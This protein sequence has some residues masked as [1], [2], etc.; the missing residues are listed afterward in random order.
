MGQQ[1]EI[2]DLDRAVCG[3]YNDIKIGAG[4]TVR[5]NH[6]VTI[7]LTDPKKRSL[8]NRFY[9]R[10]VHNLFEQSATLLQ[11]DREMGGFLIENM[12]LEINNRQLV[13]FPWLLWNSESF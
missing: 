13:R 2:F 7:K 1:S 8:E 10:D 11:Q 3:T 4:A 6:K 12:I 5:I 9:I